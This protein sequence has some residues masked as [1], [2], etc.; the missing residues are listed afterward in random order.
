[1]TFLSEITHDLDLTNTTVVRARAEEHDGM[2][3]V[4]TARAVAPLDRLTRVALGLC[5]PGGSLLAVKGE[6]AAEEL[7]A[8]EAELPKLGVER[9]SIEKLGT[10]LVAPPTT[11]VRMIRG[12]GGRASRRGRAKTSR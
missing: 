1:V 5:R 9:W 4:V 12:R 6:R 3:D 7:R 10:G 11:V 2:Y 8:V